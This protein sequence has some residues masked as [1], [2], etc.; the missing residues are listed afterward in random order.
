MK[1]RWG[2]LMGKAVGDIISVNAPMGVIKYELLE[3]RAL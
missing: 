1:A 2:T 3:I